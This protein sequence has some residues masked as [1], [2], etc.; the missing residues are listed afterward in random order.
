MLTQDIKCR[1]VITALWSFCCGNKAVLHFVEFGVLSVFEA[2]FFEHILSRCSQHIR[3]FLWMPTV[4]ALNRLDRKGIFIPLTN[5]MLTT[6]K[7]SL[8]GRTRKAFGPCRAPMCV[9]Q[10]GPRRFP[11]LHSKTPSVGAS[12]FVRGPRA[13]FHTY[14]E[15]LFGHTDK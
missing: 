10:Q 13:H 7:N 14:R 12:L 5:C 11:H 3:K 15:K 1:T 8:T 4:C 6:F 9:R 2:A